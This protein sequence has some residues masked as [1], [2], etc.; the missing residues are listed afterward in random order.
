MSLGVDVVM[1]YLFGLDR[2]GGWKNRF[3]EILGEVFNE[4]PWHN[5][6]VSKPAFQRFASNYRKAD[7]FT[8]EELDRLF[9]PENFSSYQFYLFFLL[10][11]SAGIRL[12]EVRAVRAKQNRL[13]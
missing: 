7:I 12:G 10:C 2:S 6:R 4:A 9:K 8:T 5:C 1:P 13:V 11:L 3:L